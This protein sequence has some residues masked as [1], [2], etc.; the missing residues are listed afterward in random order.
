M[1]SKVKPW[2]V[3]VRPDG[4]GKY[5]VEIRRA[6]GHLWGEP[7]AYG[8]PAD[9]YPGNWPQTRPLRE[10]DT[11]QGKR[12]RHLAQA[13]EPVPEQGQAIEDRKENVPLS[14]PVTKRLRVVTPYLYLLDLPLTGP[15]RENRVPE[16]RTVPPIPTHR[17]ASR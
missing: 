10:C 8:E 17:P 12:R 13:D 15:P 5:L 16:D 1:A 3:R 7:V 11:F 9:F 14:A 6:D 2:R 4:H